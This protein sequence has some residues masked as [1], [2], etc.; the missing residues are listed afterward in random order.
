LPTSKQ[1]HRLNPFSGCIPSEFPYLVR[2]GGSLHEIIDPCGIPE[3]DK[4]KTMHKVLRT[5]EHRFENLPGYDFESRYLHLE[6]GLR[7]HYLDEGD[8][9]GPV[10]LLL[11]GE[12]TWSYLYRKMI[13]KLVTG[14]FRVIAPDLIGFGKSD[15]LMA[16]SDYTYQKH[17]G[18]MTQFIVALDL[19]AI[20]LF[21]QDWGGLIGLRLLSEMEDRFAMVI[22]SNTSLP[23]GTRPMP[24]SFLKWRAF[25]QQVPSLDIGKVVDMGTIHPLSEDVRNAYN[26]P[27]PS[28][29]YKA[30][31]RIFPALVPVEADDPEAIRNRAAWEKLRQLKK[32]FL[33]LFGDSDD[34]TRGGDKAFQ[35]AI[36]GTRGQDHK[37]IHAGHFI[38][39]D[40]GEEL[41]E[42]IL[43]FYEKNR[44]GIK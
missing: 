38:Q 10:I 4:T 40:A 36:P 25:S 3:T 24:E 15:K 32:P 35:H 23:A 37:I 30:G 31:A 11:H 34:I 1:N 12:P 41:T 20:V 19:S 39:E 17:L 42:L 18:W 16:T 33:T 2:E 27:F 21:C 26:A 7:L 6:D 28:D 43:E 5:P 22:A 8:P 9:E 14:G 44:V 29:D 13:P